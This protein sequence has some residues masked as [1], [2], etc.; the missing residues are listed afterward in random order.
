MHPCMLSLSGVLSGIK[1]VREY[2][3]HGKLQ[4]G[5]TGKALARKRNKGPKV[6]VATKAVESGGSK[7][8]SIW[9]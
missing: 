9:Q 6:D 4:A 2:D 8:Y 7:A 3:P 1:F 5:A